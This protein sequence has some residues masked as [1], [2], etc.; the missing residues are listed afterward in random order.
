MMICDVYNLNAT[1]GGTVALSVDYDAAIKAAI[2]DSQSVADP[3]VVSCADTCE[4][5]AIVEC[6]KVTWQTGR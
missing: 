3:V 4:D 2:D 5:I 1:F 6:G